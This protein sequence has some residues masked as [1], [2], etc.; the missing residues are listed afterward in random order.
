MDEIKELKLE[1]DRWHRR[2]NDAEIEISHLKREVDSLISAIHK[3][4]QERD[5]A[6]RDMSGDCDYCKDD[7]GVCEKFLDDQC[8]WV[9]QGVNR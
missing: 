6:I 3:L 4:I 9:W 2:F 5:M 8:K 7:G 1:Q